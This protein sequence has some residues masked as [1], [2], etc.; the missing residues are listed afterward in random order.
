MAVPSSRQQ[1]KA[2]WEAGDITRLLAGTVLVGE[3]LCEAVE[4]RA[5][6]HVLDVATGHGNTAL[7]AARRRAVVTGIDFV[8]SLVAL[9]RQR[10]E[11]ERL[12]VDFRIGNAEQLEF[13]DASFDCTLSTFGMMFAPHQEAA[14]RELLRVTR[15]GGAIGLACWTP[16]GFLGQL[17]D[18]L[19][20][21]APLEGDAPPPTRWGTEKGLR[22][23]LGPGCRSIEVHR[24][25]SFLRSDSPAAYVAY[26][27]LFAGPAVRA[28]AALDAQEQT[29]LETDALALVE[30]MNR[31]GDETLYL[32][33]EYLEVVARRAGP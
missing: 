10:A 22:E 7:S 8:P 5:T 29:R 13:A 27:R 25:T 12:P 32:P 6:R 1:E 26:Y 21:R 28:F 18:L 15:P 4:L 17:F 16:E 19:D 33:S 14:A 24:R 3:L 23:L 20:S 31:S 30:R 9:A 11:M 2:T